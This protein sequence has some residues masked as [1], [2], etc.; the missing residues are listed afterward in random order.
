MGKFFDIIIM[1]LI[2][3]LVVWLGILALVCVPFMLLYILIKIGF[4]KLCELIHK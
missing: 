3:T 2:I 1:T 4:N